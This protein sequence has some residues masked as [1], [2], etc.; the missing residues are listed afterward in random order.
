MA[1][2]SIFSFSTG[3]SLLMRAVGR[4]WASFQLN[5][6][7]EAL[8]QKS[9]GQANFSEL[10]QQVEQ[11]LGHIFLH[12]VLLFF[13]SIFNLMSIRRK[14]TWLDHLFYFISL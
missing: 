3:H 11:P 8:V 4:A 6:L 1:Q 2:D 12:T 9:R 5:C 14:F 7:Y 13:L 10:K